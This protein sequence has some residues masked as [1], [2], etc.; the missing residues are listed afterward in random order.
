MRARRVV[1]V[2][3]V[4]AA[5]AGVVGVASAFAT[6]LPMDGWATWWRVVLAICATEVLLV[7]GGLATTVVSKLRGRRRQARDAHLRPGVLRAVAAFTAGGDTMADLV[8]LHRRH[9]ALV[10]HVLADLLRTLAPDARPPVIHVALALGAVERWRRDVR[11]R[12]RRVR[13]AAVERLGTLPA[14]LAVDRLLLALADPDE[15]VRRAAIRG[16]VQTENPRILADAT[17]L[18]ATRSVSER[19]IFIDALRDHPRLIEPAIFTGALGSGDPKTVLA[20]LAMVQA[21]G[22]TL[23]LLAVRTLLAA[24]DA[25]VRAA[26]AETAPHLPR[27]ERL[28][29][30]LRR[31]LDDPEPAVRAAGL[32][33]LA[34]LAPDLALH[35]AARCLRQDDPAIVVASAHA[36]AALGRPGRQRLEAVILHGA[37]LARAAAVEALGRRL[38]TRDARM[39]AA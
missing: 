19:A 38:T 14:T 33:A 17:T 10:E 1:V 5:L 9:G 32:G 34:R 8:V 4:L 12:R 31:L 15:R 24:G 22:R 18:V 6:L 25:R 3:E 7:W 21:C 36:L 39:G 11:A 29:Q 16:L 26:A 27:S 23:D 20:T 37:P 28:V 35:P 30:A 13:A 2:A